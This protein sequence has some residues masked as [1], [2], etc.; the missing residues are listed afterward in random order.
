MRT[1]V[2]TRQ[3]YRQLSVET[4][5]RIELAV[6][7][8]PVGIS[9][10]AVPFWVQ[11]LHAVAA[12]GVPLFT[13]RTTKISQRQ[14]LARAAHNPNLT[15]GFYGVRWSRMREGFLTPMEGYRGRGLA[16][17]EGDCRH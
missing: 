4:I 17:A 3:P 7:H 9:Q 10:P 8:I 2:V 12:S 13:H 5:D 14:T 1:R 6:D 11:G 15:T 16:V